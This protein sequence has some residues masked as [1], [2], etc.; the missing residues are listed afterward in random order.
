MEQAAKILQVGLGG[1]FVLLFL[2]FIAPLFAGILNIGNITGMAVS[3]F[4]FIIVVCFGR[5]MDLFDQSAPFRAAVIVISAIAGI[6]IIFAAFV[7][8][9]M[10]RQ[11]ERKPAEGA[12]MVVLGCQIHGTSPS[13]M[14]QRRLDAAAAY[15]KEHPNISCIVAGGQGKDEVVSEAQ[16]MKEYLV[17]KGISADRIY[18]EDQS[19]STAENLEYAKKIIE[20]NGLSSDLAIASDYYHQLRASVIA[21]KL[22]MEAGSVSAKTPLW[23]LPTYWVREWYGLVQEWFLK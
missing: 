3:L 11:A 15:L 10:V 8:V 23:L 2:W 19:A 5:V 20:D 17:R 6:C 9:W 16:V 22:G 12:T 14:L 4:F 7:S 18:L 1:I 13:L 21:G